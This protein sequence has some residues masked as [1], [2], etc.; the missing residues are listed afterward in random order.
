[1]PIALE[2]SDRRL[3]LWVGILLVPMLLL[4]A[5]FP[6]R[7]AE[8]GIPGSESAQSR[9]AKAA[10][11]LLEEQGYKVE[12]WRTS[13]VSLPADPAGTALILA[14]PLRP[15]TKEERNA[16]LAYLAR[17]GRILATGRTAPSYLP[18]AQLDLGP[19]GTDSWK[20]YQPEALSSLT[21]GGAI[22]MDPDGY[23][24]SGS[25]KYIVHYS[26]E[27]KPVVVSYKVGKGEVVWWASST[28]LTNAGIRESGNLDLFLNSL[29]SKDSRIFWDEY[30]HAMGRS[31]SSYLKERPLIYSVVQ[32]GL[33]FLALLF[34]FSRR[35][36]P[37]HPMYVPSRLSP[38]EFTQTL[39]SLYRRANATHAAL[40]VPYQRFR[41]LV[42][43]RLGLNANAGPRDL[44]AAIRE[45]LGY[46]DGDLSNTLEQIESALRNPAP[47]EAQ[48]L[49]LVKRLNQHAAN[50]KL[51]HPEQ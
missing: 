19:S 46:K 44:A 21:R 16:L 8:S 51:I 17:G 24:K 26:D 36:G 45:R 37:I 1:M 10:Y 13:P 4:L 6:G 48:V 50:L 9:G 15:P 18:E 49:T 38:L 30:F 39:G 40:E 34:T 25:A 43:K 14:F 3:L 23:W 22:K 47:S 35:H 7:E 31:M 42:G 11:L 29:G 2:K 20:E 5:L 28:P 32:L 41:Y 33:V 12:R 27:G